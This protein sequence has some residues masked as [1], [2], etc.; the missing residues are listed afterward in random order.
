[1]KHS[2]NLLLEYLQSCGTIKT[3]KNLQ[4]LRANIEK[5]IQFL[6]GCLTPQKYL[7][8]DQDLEIDTLVYGKIL[9]K[10]IETF[11]SNWP[12]LNNLLDSTVRKLFIVEGCTTQMFNESILSLINALK[13]AEKEQNILCIVLILKELLKSD[14]LFSAIIDSCKRCI[15]MDESS[16]RMKKEHEEQT[17]EGI[18]QILISLPNRVANKAKKKTPDCFLPKTYAKILSFHLTR[19]IFFLNDGLQYGVKSNV[20]ILSTLLSKMF[21][22]MDCTHLTPLIDIMSEWCF[23]NKN[24][25]KSL[26]QSL[27]AEMDRKSVETVVILILK[28]CNSSSGTHNFLGNL[29]TNPTWKYI[30]T[31]KVPLMSWYSDENLMRNLISY[32]G[33]FQSERILNELLLKLL[34]IWGD[35]SALNHT[36]FEQHLYITKLIILSIRLLKNQ[37]SSSEKREI[38]NLVFHGISAHLE[39]TQGLIVAIGM[40]TG[41]IIAEIVNDDS[42]SK[43][44]FEY[45]S[46]REDAQILVQSMRNFNIVYQEKSVNKYKSILLIGN[47]EFTSVSSRKIYDLGVECKI[48]DSLEQEHKTH[49]V[50][51]S[52]LITKKAVE[53]K[54]T[55]SQHIEEELDSD[56]DLVPYD[57]SNDKEI[58]ELLRPTYLRDLRENLVN[59]ESNKNPEIF[60]ESMKVAEELILSQLPGDDI[61]FGLELLEILVTLRAHC[62]VDDF[63]KLTFKACVA[64][65]TIFPKECAEYLCREFYSKAEHHSINHRVFFL[66]I[67]AESARKLSRLEI[68]PKS[69]EVEIPK[70]QRRLSKQVSLFINIEEG[71]KYETLYDDDFEV[72]NSNNNMDW[73]EIVQKRIASKTKRFAHETK[74]PKTMMNKFANVVSSFFYPLLYGFGR[75]GGYVY[76]I[77]RE[78]ADLDNHLLVSFLKTL[79]TIMVAAQN[80]P[81]STKMGKEILDLVWILRYHKDARVRLGAIE[82][83]AAVVSSVSEQSL[84]NE[85]L[86]PLTEVRL[87]LLDVTQ[88]VV[89]GESDNNCRKLGTQVLFLIES[90]LNS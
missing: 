43:L 51:N 70:K 58:S 60:S 44:K 54:D 80:C 81:L 85:L 53:I 6:P 62:Y 48:F 11:D 66:E 26:T 61:S 76:N 72:S 35:R 78:L 30:L 55:K 33:C 38:Q 67:L 56:D 15:H 37:L 79:G 21:L 19:S 39:S 84:I 64:I 77:S 49:V 45:D 36:S 82:N 32:L 28:H 86:E 88:K 31:T 75:Q 34:H 3:Q 40:I 29:A 41:E 46:L 42:P 90:I 74:R 10:V 4:T 69:M 13:E 50:D 9:E 16:R 65:V 59:P 2:T 23:E 22:V 25:I 52:V 7:N 68:Q 27:L 18:V 24:N 87:W 12:L 71:K 83:V 89:G 17:W 8:L 5:F 47:L 63:E 73:E 1:M 20:R 14:A 57:M